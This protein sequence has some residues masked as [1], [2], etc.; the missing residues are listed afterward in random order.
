MQ[1]TGIEPTIG[2]ESISV[3]TTF[4][5]FIYGRL[6]RLRIRTGEKPYKCNICG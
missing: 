6:I 4:S 3:P 1:R 2:N 5:G